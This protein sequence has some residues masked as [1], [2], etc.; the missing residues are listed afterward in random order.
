M[1]LKDSF[2]S[3]FDFIT[4]FDDWRRDEKQSLFVHYSPKTIEIVNRKCPSLKL[5]NTDLKYFS[6]D[7]NC[8]HSGEYTTTAR[9]VTYYII[10]LQKHFVSQ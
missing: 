9:K 3:W 2:K 1:K 7:F 10:I 5:L 6:I 4:K 8:V